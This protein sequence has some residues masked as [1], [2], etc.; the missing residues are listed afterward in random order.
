MVKFHQFLI[1]ILL[2]SN[3]FRLSAQEQVKIACVGFYN[4]ENLYDTINDPLTQDEEFLPKGAKHYTSAVYW[5]KQDHMSRVVADLGKEKTPD[6]IAVLGMAEIENETVIR[7][8]IN[9]P[10]L[11]KRN[12][13]IVHY[14][15]PDER[16]VDVAL[17]YQPK[18]FTVLQSRAI[19]LMIYNEDGSWRK[20]RDILFVSGLLDGDTIHFLVN[21]WPSRR[22][23]ETATKDYRNAA[24]A[25]NKGIVDS[26]YAVNPEAKV[27]IMGDLNDD[28]VNDSVLKVLGAHKSIESTKQGQ[29]FNAVYENYQK[30]FGSLAYNDAWNQFDQ[31]ML[32]YPLVKKNPT[33]YHYYQTRVFNE[34]YLTEKAGSFAGYPKRTFGGDNYI[35]GYSDHFP[36]YVFL[37]KKM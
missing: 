22:G 13:Q 33:G 19:P 31:I 20:T 9:S 23:G 15:S 7:D 36:V 2:L 37:V 11:A 17:I 12:Y 28:P 10:K 35:G 16:G 24:A 1:L 32:T 8:L 18:Y 26:L 25:V 29:I 4:F 27:V 6:G 34:S 3:A 21:H 14:D 5:D 30:G